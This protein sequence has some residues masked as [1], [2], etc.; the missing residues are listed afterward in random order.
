ML[1]PS[2]EIGGEIAWVDVRNGGD[3]GR[4]E[5]SERGT[6]TSSPQGLGETALRGEQFDRSHSA[7]HQPKTQITSEGKPAGRRALFD[8]WYGANPAITR[9]RFSGMATCDVAIL[10]GQTR[11]GPN[12]GRQC[13]RFV[14]V[15]GIE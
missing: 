11:E 4:P 9:M 8:R 1:A 3:E 15:R 6:G 10:D 7:H 5:D 13:P 2:C 14:P 12:K